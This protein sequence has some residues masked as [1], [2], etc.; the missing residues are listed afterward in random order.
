[1]TRPTLFTLGTLMAVVSLA[2]LSRAG[3]PPATSRPASPG[4]PTKH[5]SQFVAPSVVSGGISLPSDAIPVVADGEV[6]PDSIP[7]FVAY[8]H[9][10]MAISLSSNPSEA[11]VARREMHL[12]LAG[13]FGKDRDVVQGAVVGVRSELDEGAALL[14]S[15]TPD[16]SAVG[17]HR[18]RKTELLNVAKERMLNDLSLEGRQ[19]LE[20]HITRNIKRRIKIYGSMPAAQ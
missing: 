2:G 9:F 12:T 8:R 1:M 19:K 14:R 16:L 13:L 11:D 10:I 4:S 6:D 18:L 3:A 5:A 20:R 17:A 15:A 7:D